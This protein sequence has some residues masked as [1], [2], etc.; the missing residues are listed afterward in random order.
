MS[1][2][3]HEG[4]ASSKLNFVVMRGFNFSDLDAINHDLL[5]MLLDGGAR[6]FVYPTNSR[7]SATHDRRIAG[8]V[9]DVRG[10]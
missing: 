10:E 4:L 9:M 3:L 8:V 6:H 5:H 1:E 2:R 7:L